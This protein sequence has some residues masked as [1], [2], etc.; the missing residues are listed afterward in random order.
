MDE[1]VTG[2]SRN[3]S[4]TSASPKPALL[5]AWPRKL[6]PWTTQPAG[7]SSGWRVSSRHFDCFENISKE[8]FFL[9]CA[10]GENRLVYPVGF[11][12]FSGGL[13]VSFLSLRNFP[14]GWEVSLP[15]RTSCVLIIFLPRY[16][17]GN[18]FITP[19]LPRVCE[20]L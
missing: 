3:D 17:G 9:I 13:V 15:F 11:R 19:T 10:W 18:C 7:N 1:G 12:D 16:L 4:K 8:A 14:A 2:R 20:G 5:R 6:E